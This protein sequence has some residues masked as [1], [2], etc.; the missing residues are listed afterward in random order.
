MT[1]P[2]E[3]TLRDAFREWL[4]SP[5]PSLGGRTPREAVGEAEG[6]RRVHQM[7]K[8]Q[9]NHHT[10]NPSRGSIPRS[11]GASSKSTRSANHSRT[12]SSRARWARAAGSP[13]PCRRQRSD[14]VI[15]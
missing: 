5:M 11:S 2:P 6:R 4:D 15:R 3:T 10:H 9:E 12:S 13:R 14:H 1:S 7:L 8:E